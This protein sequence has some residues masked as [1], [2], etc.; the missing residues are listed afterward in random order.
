LISQKDGWEASW[1]D[2]ANRH[3]GQDLDWIYHHDVEQS[4][5]KFFKQ[6][7]VVTQVVDSRMENAVVS[8]EA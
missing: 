4:L 7:R 6:D 8:V 3:Y 1:I 2:F 5:N